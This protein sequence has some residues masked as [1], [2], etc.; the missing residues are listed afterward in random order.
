MFLY[1][2]LTACDSAPK[3][4]NATV[5]HNSSHITYTCE[6]NFVL[7]TGETNT[8]FECICTWPDLQCTGE[9]LV[10]V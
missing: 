4:A 3:I 7:E 6:D 9:I 2:A 5:V 8:T 1:I 10:N